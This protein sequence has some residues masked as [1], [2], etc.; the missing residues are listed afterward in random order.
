MKKMICMFLAFLI[1]IMF[2]AC[3]S[4]DISTESNGSKVDSIIDS[5]S[6]EKFNGEKKF[7]EE[8]I[9]TWSFCSD[10]KNTTGINTI[11][12]FDNYTLNFDD[13]KYEWDFHS[14]INS[15]S[16]KQY[17]GLDFNKIEI[18][19]FEND[20]LC[21]QFKI[22]KFYEDDEYHFL[23]FG[24]NQIYANNNDFTIIDI[25]LDNYQEYFELK[26]YFVPH[27]DKF[28]DFVDSFDFSR[29]LTIKDEFKV[30]DRY[31]TI[32]FK[33]TES[34]SIYG[35]EFDKSNETYK[36]LELLTKFDDVYSFSQ[37]CGMREDG[38]YSGRISGQAYEVVPGMAYQ[39]YAYVAEYPDRV[40]IDGIMGKLYICKW[41]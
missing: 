31:S 13:K 25:T 12:I 22:S 1:C 36:L 29:E 15:N 33:G 4:D 10:S 30:F 8:V 3:G 28:G 27:K 18:D 5:N 34:T 6:N 35:F 7:M 17:D 32:E 14:S 26:D 41:D 21:N 9:G 24:A 19:V 38:V 11:E 20:E 39:N 40:T 2:S 37:S 16:K 23:T